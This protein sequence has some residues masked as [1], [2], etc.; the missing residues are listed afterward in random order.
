MGK[1]RD[2]DIRISDVE[3]VEALSTLD[4]HL[5]TGR[6]DFAE[7]EE[8]C[9]RAAAARTRGELEA[10]FD[11]LPAPHPDLSSATR[12]ASLAKKAGQLVAKPGSLAH[13]NEIE[14]RRE[15]PASSG[16]EAVAGLT[17]VLGIPGAILLTIFLGMWWLF[18]PVVVVVAVAAGLSEAFKKP[19]PEDG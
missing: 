18:I 16:M 11:D 14:R 4:T 19:A 3:R 9:S 2:A 10:L 12:P 5:S 6:L 7:H 17:A 8:R 13:R 15:T 1:A